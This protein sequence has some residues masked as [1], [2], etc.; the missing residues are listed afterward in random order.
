ML[1]GF[2]PGSGSAT[3]EK[4]YFAPALSFCLQVCKQNLS[5]KQ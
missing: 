3:E 4:N 5:E 2:G 1:G